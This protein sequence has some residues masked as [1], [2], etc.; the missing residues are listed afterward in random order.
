MFESILFFVRK[1]S[2]LDSGAEQ[3]CPTQV[4]HRR[5]SGSKT[6]AAARWASFVT[7]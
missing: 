6:P 1:K 3:T 7:F 5:G 4:Y 2:H